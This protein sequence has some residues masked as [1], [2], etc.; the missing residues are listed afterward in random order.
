MAKIDAEMPNAAS[1]PPANVGLRNSP[2][3]NIGYRSVSSA[4]TNIASNTPE[5]AKQ[6]TTSRSPNPRSL[7]SISANTSSDSAAVN[8]TKPVQSGR[9]GRGSRDSRTRATVITK[10]ASPI[11]R[12]TKKIQRQDRPEVRP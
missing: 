6:A 11:G 7:D 9:R 4:S 12:L 8:A 5:A 2:R 3:S 1:A 10:A